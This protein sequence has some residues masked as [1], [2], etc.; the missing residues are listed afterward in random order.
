MYLKIDISNY[1]EP[2][3]PLPGVNSVTGNML[4]QRCKE[5][6]PLLE[7]A[8]LYMFWHADQ[9]LL[10]GVSQHNILE[11]FDLRDWMRLKNLLQ[12]RRQA[13]DTSLLQIFAEEDLP[14]L[15][16][17]GITMTLPPWNTDH[18]NRY[19]CLL[20]VAVVNGS[21]SSIR[22]LWELDAHA[23]SSNLTDDNIRDIVH[24]FKGR[25]KK[26]EI[27]DQPESYHLL[28][29]AAQLDNENVVSIL[30]EKGNFNLDT[31]DK[32]GRTP[33]SLAAEKFSS[34]TRL[35]LQTGKV[36]VDSR[37]TEG[38]SPLSWA[39]LRGNS[40]NVKL[41]YNAYQG[42]IDSKDCS[43]QSPLSLAAGNGDEIVVKWLLVTGKVDVNSVDSDDWTPLE[44]AVRSGY[45][46]T[47]QIL[48]RNGG[49]I[50]VGE[51]I[52]DI[53]IVAAARHGCTKLLKELLKYPGADIEVTGNSNKTLLGIASESG[54]I[55][56]VLLLLERGANANAV[57]ESGFTPLRRAVQSGHVEIAK[58]LLHAGKED[59]NA[60][61]PCGETFMDFAKI[62]DDV[63]SRES[64]M[65]L[66]RAYGA[67]D[68]QSFDTMCS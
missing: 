25:V 49:R 21:A 26:C 7:Y 10:Y 43:G 37:D 2:L 20:N 23:P 9:A 32:D 18:K 66:L 5:K 60:K 11:N 3:A 1:L 41:L 34:V 42:N 15:I 64:M 6:F 67:K 19:H 68:E 47:V 56:T 35:L 22:A 53:P 8:V 40:D 51:S 48:R 4:R 45:T 55:D 36:D 61:D 12:N 38:R 58:L 44:Y 29:W 17:M 31:K 28:S 13:V 27:A 52:R 63:E 50:I 24:C 33:L 14:N 57:D 30:L 62:I 39:A 16:K 65:E 54:H 46:S 59:L